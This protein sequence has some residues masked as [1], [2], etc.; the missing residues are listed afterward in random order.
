MRAFLAPPKARPGTRVGATYVLPPTALS[1]EDTEDVK[2]QL[3]L[4][5]K[6]GFGTPPPPYAAWKLVDGALHVPRF[7]G[8]GR[9]G[10]AEVDERVDGEALSD[11]VTFAGTLT[12]VQEKVTQVMFA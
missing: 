9:F 4:Q 2:T 6:A 12:P 7:Y 10:P 8:L 1:V 3:T 5:A 11:D